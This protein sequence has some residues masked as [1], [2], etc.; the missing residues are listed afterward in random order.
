MFILSS[1]LFIAILTS[2]HAALSSRH[3]GKAILPGNHAV[4]REEQSVTEAG[5]SNDQM[6]LAQFDNGVLRHQTK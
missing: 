6:L 1:H 3:P 5:L 4:I 2:V